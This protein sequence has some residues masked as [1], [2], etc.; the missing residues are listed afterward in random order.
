M[1]TIIKWILAAFIGSIVS[2][3]LAIISQGV[4]VII[5]CGIVAMLVGLFL[6]YAILEKS[7]LRLI[8]SIALA[9]VAFILYLF[10]YMYVDENVKS[11]FFGFLAL[12]APYI[13]FAYLLFGI[14]SG[15]SNEGKNSN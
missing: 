1:K 4:H 14:S 10:V 9:I 5:T 12:S 11:I 15:N 6:Y 7:D 3:V 2:F 8:L 13:V